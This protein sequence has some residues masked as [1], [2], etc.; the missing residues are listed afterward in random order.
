LKTSAELSES[1][2]GLQIQE[3]KTGKVFQEFLFDEVP[4]SV[5]WRKKGYVTPVKN[6][7]YKTT[8]FNSSSTAQKAKKELR[9]LFGKLWSYV[10]FISL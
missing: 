3:Q 10:Q 7:V 2:K 6:Q 1:M 4:K 8:K 5:D 9:S